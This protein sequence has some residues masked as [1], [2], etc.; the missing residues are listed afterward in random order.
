[1]STVGS[2]ARF[3]VGI[4]LSIEVIRDF[5]MGSP[6]S[7]IA[8]VLSGIFLALSVAFFVFKF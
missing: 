6:V 5:A 7:D 8:L 2:Y 3:I 1:M 4:V